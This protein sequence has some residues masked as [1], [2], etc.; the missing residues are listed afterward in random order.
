M[1]N[2][3]LKNFYAFFAIPQNKASLQCIKNIIKAS[4]ITSR[5]TLRDYKETFVVFWREF[6]RKWKI[7]F[8][9]FGLFF[10]WCWEVTDSSK[11]NG[12]RYSRILLGLFLNTL[13]Q[14]YI[15]LLFLNCCSNSFLFPRLKKSRS[16][17]LSLNLKLGC[18]DFIYYPS[19]NEGFATFFDSLERIVEKIL[20][21]SW[22]KLRPIIF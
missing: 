8:S 15:F 22:E 14:I 5:Y 11:K 21:P 20:R 19:I 17:L 10:F 9:K 4:L 1:K 7:F 12:S 13:T 3:R 6:E 2:N 18:E 16:R